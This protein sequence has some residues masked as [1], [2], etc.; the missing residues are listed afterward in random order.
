MGLNLNGTREPYKEFYGRNTDQMSALIADARVPM[1][2][3]QLMQK[4]LDVRN[5]DAKVKSAWIDNYFDSGDAVVY[6]PNGDVKV[7]LDS[8]TLRE[9]TPETQRNGGALVIGE[10]VYQ[11]LQG[12]IF[13]KGK[14]GKINEWLTRAQVKAHP[15]WKVLARG[16]TL[17]NDYTD[18]TAGEYQARFAKDT[19]LDD[20]T[21]MGFFPG[22]CGGKSP[23]MRAF[24][25]Y[26][27]EYGS[28][29]IGG[30][31]LTG[32]LVVLLG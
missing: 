5:A 7:V 25:V 27:L 1:N 18:F 6:H 22:S 26:G 11:A 28:D 2:V 29:V 32:G 23:E 17:L 24:Y 4:R 31:A 14:L 16:Q 9:M 15:V 20:I 13:K 19:P 12:E 21:I 10:E 3:S 30:G 8:Q